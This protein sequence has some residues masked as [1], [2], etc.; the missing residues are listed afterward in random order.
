MES[1]GTIKIHNVLDRE[2]TPYVTHQPFSVQVQVWTRLSLLSTVKIHNVLHIDSV[3]F[4]E[5]A[6]AIHHPFSAMT[7]DDPLF[8]GSSSSLDTIRPPINH[9]NPQLSPY[10]SS[11]SLQSNGDTCNASFTTSPSDDSLSDSE[12]PNDIAEVCPQ[13]MI[14][15]SNCT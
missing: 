6:W 11:S 2:T 7:R 9:K 4:R 8:G 13:G 10:A 15:C 1:V 12:V 5:T 3:L 14:V